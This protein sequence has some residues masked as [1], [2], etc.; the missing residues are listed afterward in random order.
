MSLNHGSRPP[1]EEPI[2]LSDKRYIFER[3]I[4]LPD[5]DEVEDEETTTA[6]VAEMEINNSVDESNQEF[7]ITAFNTSVK[8]ARKT[9]GMRTATMSL[10]C[11]L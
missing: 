4:R 9:Y 7:H 1:L 6:N 5:Y 11:H 2:D 8:S 10:M 3:D